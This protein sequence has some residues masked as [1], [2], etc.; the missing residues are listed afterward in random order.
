L[1]VFLADLFAC[2]D[3]LMLFIIVLPEADILISDIVACS[4]EEASGV[5]IETVG[6]SFLEI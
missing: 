2:I 5:S 1:L 6:D 4:R 3:Q